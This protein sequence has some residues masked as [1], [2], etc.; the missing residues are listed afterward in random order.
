MPNLVAVKPKKLIYGLETHF[1][2]KISF[3]EIWCILY[4]RV[5]LRD[6]ILDRRNEFRRVPWNGLWAVLVW[7]IVGPN[8][9]FSRKPNEPIK[10]KLI[11]FNS[12]PSCEGGLWT[13]TL[14]PNILNTPYNLVCIT[15]IFIIFV[16]IINI[17][18][19]LH[20]FIESQCNNFYATTT[21]L[22]IL[23]IF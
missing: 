23:Y 3:E 8:S 22:F 16:F 1:W 13:S 2:W 9:G 6:N 17:Y 4:W 12:S 18:F 10:E 7:F 20:S 14:N 21:A 11:L 15:Y 5:K 19:F